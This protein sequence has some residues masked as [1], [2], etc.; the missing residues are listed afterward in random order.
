MEGRTD[1]R[2]E[3]EDN[4]D[5][6]AWGGGNDE[7]GDGAD[8]DNDGSDGDGEK[9]LEGEDGVNLAYEGPTQLRILEHGGVEGSLASTTAFNVSF[10]KHFSFLFFVSQQERLC[11]RV[12]VGYVF[13]FIL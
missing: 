1:K 10:H 4:V 2:N 8:E 12:C 3:D 9:Q 11:R 7:V 13:R 6:K 5:N